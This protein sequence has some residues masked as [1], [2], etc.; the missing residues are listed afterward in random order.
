M[1]RP[2]PV[3]RTAIVVGLQ[4]H[5]EA[6]RIVRLLTPENGR[7]TAHARNAR[8]S[9]RRFGGALDIGNRIEATLRPPKGGWWGLDSALLEDGRT[10]ARGDLDRI[11]LM[12]YATEVCGQL[13][14]EDHPEPKLYGLLD[15]AIT[16]I[17]AL[18]GPVSPLFRLGLEAKALTF[19]GIAPRL[20]VCMTCGLQPEGQ[21]QLTTAGVHHYA[22]S[23]DGEAVSTPWLAAVETARR[24]P[25]R[26]SI[27]VPVPPGPQWAL[28]ELLEQHLGRRLRSR[29]ILATLTH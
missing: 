2:L 26:E 7:I 17:D 5:R 11:A 20:N 12:A 21:M 22:C 24:T 1:S 3:H 10:H 18:S 29:S 27:D 19:A 28:A 23:R 6:D 4:E 14:R 15:M 25:L 8:K 9:S 16:V 13:A